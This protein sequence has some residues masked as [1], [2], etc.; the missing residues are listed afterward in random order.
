MATARPRAERRA[1]LRIFLNLY[2]EKTQRNEETVRSSLP[3][4]F[5]LLITNLTGPVL[6]GDNLRHGPGRR[7]TFAAIGL[8]WPTPSRQSRCRRDR[9]VT[10]PPGTRRTSS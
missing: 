3:Q 1:H 9:S 8:G 7:G 6:G 5:A 4:E 2:A 10:V